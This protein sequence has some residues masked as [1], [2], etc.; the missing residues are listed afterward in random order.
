M[1]LSA[2]RCYPRVCDQRV[3]SAII[4]MFMEITLE[5]GDRKMKIELS[6]PIDISIPLDFNGAQPNAYGVEPASSIACEYGQL[7][8]DTRRGGSCNF[9]Q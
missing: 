5:F 9:E 1:I 4:L 2:G 6:D 3:A 7:I 8:G